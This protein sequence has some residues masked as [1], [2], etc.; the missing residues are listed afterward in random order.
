MVFSW[1]CG[2]VVVGDGFGLLEKLKRKSALGLVPRTY[3][4]KVLK[5]RDNPKWLSGLN[6]FVQFWGV[7]STPLVLRTEPNKFSLGFQSLLLK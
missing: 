4:G 6:K 3:L 5:S 7:E 1:Q 2:G